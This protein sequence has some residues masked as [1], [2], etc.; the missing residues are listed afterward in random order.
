MNDES[1]NAL[2]KT[3]EEPPPHSVLIL[4]ATD[5]DR[6][7]PTIR[8]R[9]QLLRF[10]PL[11]EGDLV[12]LLV[13]QGLVADAAAA[14]EI[15]QLADG[16]LD[17]AQTLLDP[18][19][20]QQREQ[21]F[22][23]LGAE[24]FNSLKVTEQVQKAVDSATEPAEQRRR[25][26]WLLRLSV[27]FYRAVLWSLATGD[28]RGCLSIPAAEKLAQRWS[29]APEILDALTDLLDRIQQTSAEL[30]QNVVV[31]LALETLWD[32]LGRRLRFPP[33]G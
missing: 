18:E 23:V 33:L 11:S 19:F 1:A 31:A 7:L 8:S 25:A 17:T 3:L 9:C 4:L 30:D 22:A 26:Q 21:L 32:D 15:A 24:R 2:L 27:E 14:Q 6:I 29:P 10:S 5:L 12:T 20:R 16:S 28:M 13:E